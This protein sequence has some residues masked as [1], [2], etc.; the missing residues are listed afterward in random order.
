MWHTPFHTLH[1]DIPF[2]DVLKLALLIF[3]VVMLVDV[4]QRKFPEEN[5]RLMWLLIILLVPLGA[6][7]YYFV[8]R[9]QGTR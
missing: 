2:H 9:K 1:G 7:V 6:V 5:T 8:G 4:A 3:W